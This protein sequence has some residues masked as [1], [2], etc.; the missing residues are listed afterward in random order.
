[1]TTLYLY[2]HKNFKTTFVRE[3]DGRQRE[4]FY[5]VTHD[6]CSLFKVQITFPR[7][8]KICPQIQKQ[9]Q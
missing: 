6:M 9:G 7:N 4:Q 5:L 8:T 2:I 3:E 1:M